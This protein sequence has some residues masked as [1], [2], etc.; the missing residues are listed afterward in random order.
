M[1]A[2]G[3]GGVCAEAS[4]GHRM[5]APDCHPVLSFSGRLLKATFLFL[6]SSNCCLDVILIICFV[7]PMPLCPC[8]PLCLN[9]SSGF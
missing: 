4:L 6:F 9:S 7:M 8:L 3:A 1:A 5:W 2:L